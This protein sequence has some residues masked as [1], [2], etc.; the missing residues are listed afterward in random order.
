MN[1]QQERFDSIL[2]VVSGW[3]VNIWFMHSVINM[4]VQDAETDRRYNADWLLVFGPYIHQNRN[5]LQRQF[6]EETDRD[7]LFMLD[8]DLVFQAEDVR[9]LHAVADREG[10]GVY[11][12]PYLIENGTMVCGP[13][14]DKVDYA[15]HPMVGLPSKPARVG[16]VGAG[17]TLIHRKVLEAVGP[18][19]F[20][21]LAPDAGEDL[22]F[23]WR[24]REAG[25]VPWLVP[26]CNPG[27]F[28]NVALFPH[29][30]VRNVIG[31]EINLTVV[32]RQQMESGRIP[33][34][35]GTGS[36][37]PITEGR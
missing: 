4:F 12:A 17:F 30:E 3:S 21:A 11:S 22:S 7:W 36:G 23:C 18:N 19:A 35:A 15:Y 31:D 24:A 37:D 27:H 16:V 8:N 20:A 28:K 29:G 26:A 2:G 5:E 34:I 25:Y 10:P 6:L 14:D 1:A 33:H 32:D 9:Q 13:W